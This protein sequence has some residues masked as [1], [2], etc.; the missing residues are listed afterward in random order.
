[1]SLSLKKL[2]IFSK[3]FKFV[4]IDVCQAKNCPAMS[5]NQLLQHW[6]TPII[7]RDVAKL[8]GFMQFY[9]RFIPHF[10]RSKSRCCVISFTRTTRLGSD[11]CGP[12]K[13]KPCLTQCVRQFWMILASN[14]TIIASSLSFSQTILP[15]GLAIVRANW[16]T[17]TYH[18]KP[19][20]NVCRVEALTS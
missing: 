7:V 20:I 15:K 3:Q 5:K 18:F 16:Q 17:T 8:V 14:N 12:E 10:L 4:R 19:C 6:P 1:M 13:H 9:S 11:C 2:H